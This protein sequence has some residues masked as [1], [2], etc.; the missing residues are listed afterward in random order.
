MASH[1][2]PASDTSCTSAEQGKDCMAQVNQRTQLQHEILEASSYHSPD[3]QVFM[4]TD[5]GFFPSLPRISCILSVD[6][7]QQSIPP[8]HSSWKTPASSVS[9]YTPNTPLFLPAPFVVFFLIKQ[10]KD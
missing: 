4:F 9:N 5:G 1:S 10:F 8:P 6:T 7:T 3:L 2:Q